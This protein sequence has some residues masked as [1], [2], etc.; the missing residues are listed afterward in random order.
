MRIVPHNAAFTL[1]EIMVALTVIVIILGAVYG[2]Y[3][4]ATT[5]IERCKLRTDG[6][7]EARALLGRMTQEIRCSYFSQRRGRSSHGKE[8]DGTSVVWEETDEPLFEGKGSATS[9]EFLRLVTTSGLGGPQGTAGGLYVVGYRLDAAAGT[10]CRRESPLVNLGWKG[11][12]GD[13]GLPILRDV[14]AVALRYHDGKKWRESWDSDDEK[15]LPDGVRIEVTLDRGHA[16]RS[17]RSA[18]W[19]AR[20]AGVKHTPAGAA[21]R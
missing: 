15:R 2:S 11:S 18:A 19:V 6:V 9:G 8:A 7:N 14:R 4:A 10:L 5:S 21:D 16:V 3:S 17:F 12:E 13:K 20:R 1:I